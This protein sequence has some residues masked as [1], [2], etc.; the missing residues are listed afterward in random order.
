VQLVVY[1]GGAGYLAGSL[2]ILESAGAQKSHVIALG[3]KVT[4]SISKILHAAHGAFLTTME[5]EP[6]LVV[7]YTPTSA[8]QP[9]KKF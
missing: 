9:V 6:I 5:A 7:S 4:S 1:H 3:H 8:L 2:G